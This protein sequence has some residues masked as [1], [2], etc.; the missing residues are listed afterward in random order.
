MNYE[1]LLN[2]YDDRLI[3]E[4]HT[5]SKNNK[6]F[7]SGN[8][9]WINKSLS[10]IEKSCTLAEE[11]GHYETSVGDITDLRKTESRKQELKA[12][13]WA[14]QKMIPLDA[15]VHAAQEGVSNQFELAEHLGV[16]EE[17]LLEAL[18]NFKAKYENQTIYKDYIIN[19]DP[20]MIYDGKKNLLYG[21]N[22]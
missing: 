2:E 19:F 11:V 10:T 16:T 9:I 5:L 17:F 14:H 3:I 1:A 13:R 4:E 15:L 8:I 22:L 18:E 21:G 7:Q 6:G 20:L 12:R